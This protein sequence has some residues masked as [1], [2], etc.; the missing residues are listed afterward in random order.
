[1]DPIHHHQR[2]SRDPFRRTSLSAKFSPIAVELIVVQRENKLWGK[3]SNETIVPLGNDVCGRVP[4]MSPWLQ[5]VEKDVEL[6][7]GPPFCNDVVVDND[8]GLAF[9][10]CDPFKSAFY[11]PYELYNSSRVYGNGGIWLYD[12]NV[13]CFLLA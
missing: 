5:E 7:L 9:L 11:P 1:M 3:L 12:T 6:T 2:L 10:A 4:G 8:S 13:F